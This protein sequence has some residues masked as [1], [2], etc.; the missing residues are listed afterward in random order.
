MDLTSRPAATASWVGVPEAQSHTLA[1]GLAE[2]DTLAA[3]SAAAVAA[4]MRV[5][6]VAAEAVTA[7]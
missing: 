1:V 7:N 3:D 4:A 2:A 6:V 5:A